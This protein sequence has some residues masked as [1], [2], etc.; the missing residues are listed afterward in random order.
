[1]QLQHM[2][3]RLRKVQVLPAAGSTAFPGCYARDFASFD[4]DR[5]RWITK[6]AR[7]GAKQK[8]VLGSGT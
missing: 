7:Q 1:M 4:R 5:A 3:V 8:N 6:P 2:Q